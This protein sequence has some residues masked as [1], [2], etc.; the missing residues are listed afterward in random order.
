[1]PV[2]SSEINYTIFGSNASVASTQGYWEAIKNNYAITTHGLG[3]AGW[4][5][6]SLDETHYV[7]PEVLPAPTNIMVSTPLLTNRAY[8]IRWDRSA[9]L[10]ILGYGVYRAFRE[11]GEYV[12]LTPTTIQTNQYRDQNKDV[13]VDSEQILLGEKGRGT[14][15]LEN[16]TEF[17]IRPKFCPI[18]EATG[19]GQ[20]TR[21]PADIAL[22]IDGKVHIPKFVNGETGEIILNDRLFYDAVKN[23]FVDA[24][25]PEVNSDVRISYWYRANFLDTDHLRHFPPYYKVTAIAYDL[26]NNRLIETNPAMLKGTTLNIE[27]IDWI[28]T[29]AIRRNAWIAEMAGE[30]VMAFQ[31]KRSGIVCGCVYRSEGTFYPDKSCQDCFGVG[32]IGGYD[33]PYP[34]T[35]VIPFS[36]KRFELQERGHRRLDTFEGMWAPP[37]PMMDQYDVI[38]RQNGEMYMV[39]PVKRPNH[40]GF[41]ALQQRFSMEFLN[42]HNV[43]YRLLLNFDDKNRTLQP[44]SGQIHPI[45]ANA[46]TIHLLAEKSPVPTIHYKGNTFRFPTIMY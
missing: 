8:D 1:V 23:Q 19:F 38:L 31:Q 27:Q 12:R 28:W 17:Y 20:P 6:F 5:G 3:G 10:Y 42:Y 45:G 14:W 25:L 34:L 16:N 33:G 35:I 7:A 37:Q 41:M 43:Q 40:R 9:N 39:G 15:R 26:E 13:F 44:E 21:N 11:V 18:V 46:N 24:P 32:F 22:T 30:Q 29:E 2:V 36:E 4:S